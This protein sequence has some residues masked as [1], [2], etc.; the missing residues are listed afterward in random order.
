MSI[1]NMKLSFLYHYRLEINIDDYEIVR[2]TGQGQKATLVT[3]TPLYFGNADVNIPANLAD[4]TEQ[5]GGCIA[6][7]T[8]NGE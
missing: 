8:I 4:A 3:T 1:A 2:T 6:D 7:V 5:F